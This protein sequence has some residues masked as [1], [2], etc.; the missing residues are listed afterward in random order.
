MGLDRV[1]GV[2]VEDEVEADPKISKDTLSVVEPKIR[3]DASAL[4]L[5]E[6]TPPSDQGGEGDLPVVGIVSPLDKGKEVT[7]L[8]GKR[9]VRST[10]R[11]KHIGQRPLKG[12][13]SRLT[14][15][16]IEDSTS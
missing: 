6:T 5:V 15:K 1:E 12:W 3:D 13:L 7:T 14:K 11:R 16:S 2:P 9:D 10:Y 4:V 8:R